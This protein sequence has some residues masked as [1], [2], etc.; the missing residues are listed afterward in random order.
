MITRDKRYFIKA[1]ARAILIFLLTV[2]VSEVASSV[3]QI[4]GADAAKFFE[5]FE[6]FT[7]KMAQNTI[8]I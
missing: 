2:T 5:Y 8:D 6:N 3:R 1:V 4:Q 7:Y